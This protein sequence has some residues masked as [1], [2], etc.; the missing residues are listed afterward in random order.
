[1]RFMGRSPRLDAGGLAGASI[2][3]GQAE[4]D[5]I[6]E[7]E[8]QI[9]SE[10]L[11]GLRKAGWDGDESSIRLAYLSTFSCY[12]AHLVF[13]LASFVTEAYLC[14]GILRPEINTASNP[15]SDV[16]IREINR[17]HGG[18]DENR[19]Y[20]RDSQARRRAANRV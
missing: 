2:T 15:S 11:S 3:W 9:F 19:R 7:I 13:M 16:K 1:M 10:Y 5:V 17:C 20:C 18:F 14:C 12:V 4:A 8:P 6:E